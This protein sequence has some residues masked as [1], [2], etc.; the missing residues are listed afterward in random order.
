MEIRALTAADIPGLLELWSAVP[1]L[2]LG[3]DDAEPRLALFLA[4]NP[5]TCL[6]LFL[7][8]RLAGG[9]LG[10]FDGRRG[11]LYHLAVHPDLQGRGFGRAL[12]ERVTAEFLAMGVRNIRLFVF[13]TNQRAREFYQRMGWHERDDLAV[14]AY[15]HPG[16]GPC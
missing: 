9:V 4:R 12:L 16:D 8:G 1:G 7:A 10:G 15:N 6:G 5:S 13:G 3:P 11:Y 14:M 2:G